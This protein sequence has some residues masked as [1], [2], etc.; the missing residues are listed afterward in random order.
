MP[1]VL[2]IPEIIDQHSD[3]AA[4]LWLIRDNAVKATSSF[5]LTD[6]A[7]LDERVEANLDGLRTAERRGWVFSLDELDRGGAGEF[8][9]AGILSVESDDLRRLDQVID[10]AYARPTTTTDEPY[11]PADDPWRGILSA[12]AWVD[13][14]PAANAIRR[15]LDTPRPS[16]RWLA[17]AA[18][19]AR[20]IVGQP[21]LETTLADP[22]PL[23]RAR[24]ARVIGE[25]GR[26]DLRAKLNAVLADPDEDCRFWAAWSAARLGTTEGRTA[27]A[28]FASSS[29][30]KSDLA[31]DLLLRCMS[32][33]EAKAFLRP[34][35]RDLARRRTVIRAAGIIG[36]ALYIPWLVDQTRDPLVA[37]AAGDALATITGV[38]LAVF[39]NAP[40]P[41]WGPND[42]PG[43]E[44]VS[45]DE[46]EGLPFPD[47]E[48]L[49]QWW[50]ANKGCFS[51]GTAYFLGTPKSSVNWIDLLAETTQRRRW[52]AALELALLQPNQTM[53]E[54][55]ARGGLQQQLL[56]RARA[57]R[58]A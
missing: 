37:Q 2:F 28:A 10:R 36:D 40:S 12:I 50:E 19:G 58:A 55:R 27:L 29:G 13:R 41:D 30:P 20:R 3:N 33:E 47:T 44:N 43:D 9:V 57:A 22:A 6:I 35:A 38:D 45:V 8:F 32:A 21:G 52:A 48:R 42:N 53:L 1:E 49:G 7:K 14:T 4:S 18:S 39:G 54:V 46:D 25:L 34:L 51:H 56:E 24:A 15:L 11:Y 16:T 23:V 17:V 31:L 5:R 26:T